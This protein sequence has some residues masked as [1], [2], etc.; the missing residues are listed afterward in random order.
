METREL[1]ISELPLPV[2]AAWPS[3]D[4]GAYRTA[5]ISDT[6]VALGYL[7]QDDYCENPMESCDG[8]GFIYSFHRHA[9]N[10]ISESELKKQ[11]DKVLLDCYDHGGQSWSVSGAGMQCQ[12][13]TAKGAGFWVPDSCAKEEIGRRAKAY[14]YGEIVFCKGAYQA[15]IDPD[16]LGVTVSW[17]ASFSSWSEAFSWLQTQVGMI[18]SQ[19]VQS[20]PAN[21]IDWEPAKYSKVRANSKQK[22]LG[23][24]RAAQELAQ[25][26]LEE[27]NAWLS[28]DCYERVFCQF[29][30][31]AASDEFSLNHDSVETC[32]GFIGEQYATE[33][34]LAEFDSLLKFHE[35]QN[36][37][38]KL[39]IAA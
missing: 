33:A 32:C 4:R 21:V 31:D 8:N 35:N 23:R 25:D 36:V 11:Q 39:A 18:K 14:A 38:C 22:Q 29:E 5:W 19:V 28:G 2:K 7:A 6:T 30:Y 17:Q 16:F 37:Q 1:E 13:D 10:K 3:T 12:F 15:K 20:A 9:N 27:Y 34:L 24:V 26:S